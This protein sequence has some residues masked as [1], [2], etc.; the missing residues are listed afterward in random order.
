MINPMI[1]ATQQTTR[2]RWVL[3]FLAALVAVLATI[4]SAATASAATTAGT[5][6]RVRASDVPA[7]V[8]VGPP[9]HIAAGQRLGE[10]GPQVITAV[11]TGVAAKTVVLTERQIGS[12]MDD[13]L[14]GSQFIKS[15]RTLTQYE[16]GGGFPRANADFDRLVQGVEVTDRGSGVRTATLSNGTKVNVRPDS[17]GGFPTLEVSTPG[18]PNL[19]VRY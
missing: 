14:S 5:E 2:P 8:L 15:S 11:A 10:A 19:K 7:A 3:G 12:V 18:N 9:E 16:R 13:L 17:S 1:T 6:N 4:L